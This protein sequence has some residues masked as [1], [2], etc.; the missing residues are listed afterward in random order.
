[1]IRSG[2]LSEVNAEMHHMADS[3]C[4]GPSIRRSSKSGCGCV[5]NDSNHHT[6]GSNLSHVWAPVRI[7]QR[8]V[9]QP[10]WGV[11]RPESRRSGIEAVPPRP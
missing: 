6:N 7:Q 2:P 9:V 1:M 4:H 3:V 10:T 11:S 5:G 8:S